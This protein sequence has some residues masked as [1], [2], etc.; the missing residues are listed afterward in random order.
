MRPPNFGR[1]RRAE[2]NVSAQG[3]DAPANKWVQIRLSAPLGGNNRD[4]IGSTVTLEG[5]DGAA[6]LRQAQIVDGGSSRGGQQ[7]TTLTFGLGQT[8][9]PVTVTV[10]WPDGAT[11]VQTIQPDQLNRLHVIEDNHTPDIV[12]G[13]LQGYFEPG[14]NGTA[15]FV[16]EWLTENSSL[17]T[18]DR[19]QIWSQFKPSQQCKLPTY[20]DPT[21]LLEGGPGVSTSVEPAPGGRYLHRLRWHRGECASPCYYYWQATSG[22]GS[23]WS[24]Y[25][26]Q[27]PWPQLVVFQCTVG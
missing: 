25:P 24:T 22:I 23:R 12:P 21:L 10:R 20:P 5:N 4:G 11:Q 9:S 3:A 15:D 17:A 14:P 8:V 26:A 2:V 7:S 27:Q 6:P 13:S 18:Q 19:V 1:V 16:F